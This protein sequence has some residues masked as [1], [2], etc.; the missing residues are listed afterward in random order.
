M[1]YAGLIFY[2]FMRKK[3]YLCMRNFKILNKKRK[4]HKNNM[5]TTER[6]SPTYQPHFVPEQPQ[7]ILT[8]QEIAENY[9]SVDQLH[10]ELKELAHNFYKNK[11]KS[12]LAV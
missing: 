3:L 12:S 5:N 11:S 10:T 8:K 7:R 6:T 1:S 9:V 2:T 4:Y